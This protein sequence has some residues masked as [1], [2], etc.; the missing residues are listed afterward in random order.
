MKDWERMGITS[1]LGDFDPDVV[2]EAVW[3]IRRLASEEGVELSTGE[4]VAR[5]CELWIG[6]VRDPQKLAELVVWG[7]SRTLN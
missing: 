6:G 3:L 7:E 2:R 1:H 4:I 5:L